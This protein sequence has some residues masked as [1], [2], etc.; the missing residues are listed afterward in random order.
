MEAINESFASGNS[1]LHQIDPRIKLIIIFLYALIIAVSSSILMLG[2]ALFLSIVLL[3]IARLEFKKVLKR[4]ILVNI[5]TGSV[6][7]FIPFSY[8]GEAILHIGPLTASLEGIYYALT[9]SLRANSIMLA[10]IALLATSKVTD[11]LQALNYFKFSKK[12]IYLAYFLYRYLFVLKKELTK[13][14][15]SAKARGLENKSCFK[16]YTGYCYLIAMLLIKS[17][18]RSERVY[19]AMMARGFNNKIYIKQDFDLKASDLTFLV[20]FL[21]ILLCFVLID[22]RFLI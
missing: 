10:V 20:G 21:V 12:M 1:I 2:Q 5:F 6:W 19:Q 17:Y 8:K 3:S 18:D 4:I 11:L 16:T 22:T 15:R 7:L 14:I 9:I 13:L